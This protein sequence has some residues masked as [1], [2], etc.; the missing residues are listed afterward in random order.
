VYLPNAPTLDSGSLI[1]LDLQESS[2]LGCKV[3]WEL[4]KVKG[5]FNR[6]ARAEC[7][8]LILKTLV[9][10]ALVACLPGVAALAQT[11]TRL[12]LMSGVGVPGHGGLAFGPF[13]DLAMNENQD[14]VF[15]SSL[16][17][18]RNELRAVVRSSGVS[19]TVLAFQ[20]LLAPT[21]RASY[22]GF[23]APSMNDSG[24][25]AFAATL[26]KDR[27]D[28]P[29]MIVVRQESFKV[30]V[31]ATN[32]DA[33][34]GYPGGKFEEFSAPLVTSDG[35]VLFGARWSGK[36]AGS[37]L[38]L[39]TPH[40][41]QPLQ[42]P[43]GVTPSAR[44]LLEPFFFSHDEAAFLLHGA[45]HNDALE[46]FFRAIAIQ[47]FQELKPPPD[48]TQTTELLPAR[49]GVAPVQ[50]LLVFLENGNIQTVPLAGDPTKPVLARTSTDGLPPRPAGRILSLTI[51]ARGNVI[52]AAVPVDVP[53]D[54]ALSCYCDG[55]VI[56][57][58][59]PEDFYPITQVAPGKPITSLSGDTKQTTAFIAPTANGDNTAIYV[60][61]TQRGN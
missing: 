53:N 14:I 9:G 60:T 39:S 47:T 1:R 42:L 25:V 22:E 52:F 55:Q 16:R 23:T 28:A 31:L 12:L 11:N 38:F 32:L 34:P 36:G 41:L 17:G 35:N 51:G 58:T 40:G 13:S 57:L 2:V 7:T 54:L 27:D 18:S 46:Q 6:V 48:A 59:S 49:T 3:L 56:R 30:R 19:F 20:G 43:E 24:V 33:P 44:Q 5:G 15:L 29:T 37:G 45:S 50:M 61:D 26:S 4:V 21:G 8:L 10:V